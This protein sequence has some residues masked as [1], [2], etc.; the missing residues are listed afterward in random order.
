MPDL[1]TCTLNALHCVHFLQILG[2]D[3][4]DVCYL[5]TFMVQGAS[6]PRVFAHTAKS[7]CDTLGDRLSTMTKLRHHHEQ[8]QDA[9]Q[10]IRCVNVPK[11]KKIHF[12][13][14]TN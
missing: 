11:S 13:L 10:H 5:Q 9:S 4:T 12:D 3:G 14:N 6:A 2:I 8:P 7:C 1:A